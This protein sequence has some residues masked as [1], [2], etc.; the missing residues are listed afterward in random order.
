MSGQLTASAICRSLL[1]LATSPSRR[2]VGEIQIVDTETDVLSCIVRM[3]EQ[4]IGGRGNVTITEL[5]DGSEKCRLPVASRY[6]EW[7]DARGAGNRS[8]RTWSGR[9]PYGNRMT[10]VVANASNPGI[11]DAIEVPS[12]ANTDP[13]L[14]PRQ[15]GTGYGQGLEIPTTVGMI[16]DNVQINRTTPIMDDFELDPGEPTYTNTE[17]PVQM[18]DRSGISSNDR[19]SEASTPDKVFYDNVNTTGGSPA[20]SGDLNAERKQAVYTN[21]NDFN[22]MPEQVSKAAYDQVAEIGGRLYNKENPPE[23]MSA[24]SNFREPGKIAIKCSEGWD[25][26][27]TLISVTIY[28]DY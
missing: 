28:Y 7:N 22:A 4:A 24:M 11:S 17:N 21:A 20:M 15:V 27:L 19:Q 13:I 16:Y 9:D 10:D 5:N 14:M 25:I 1:N 26:R 8:D 3:F 2:C 23:R 6:G 12:D 18:P